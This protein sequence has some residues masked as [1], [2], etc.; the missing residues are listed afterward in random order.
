MKILGISCYYHDSAAALLEDAKII[1][2]AEEERFSRIKHDSSFPSKSVEFC[3]SKSK[4]PKV[5]DYV[6]FYEKP[7][8]KFER[9]LKQALATFPYSRPLFV[10]AMK[11]WLTEKLWIK[12]KISQELQ[13]SPSKVYFSDHHA[14]HAASAFYPSPYKSAAILTIDGVGEWSTASY[15][16]GKEN[17][18]EIIKELRFPHSLGLLYSVFTAFLGFEV[19]DGEYK[20]MG[21]APYGKPRFKSK[22]K[23]IVNILDDGSIK[24]D[25]DYF[26][27]HLSPDKAFD[28]KFIQLFGEPRDKNEL[29]FTQKTGYPKFWGPKPK[30]FDLRAKKNERYADIAASIQEITEEIILKMCQHLYKE[31]NIPN[32]CLAGGV[33]LNSVA[34]GKI[35]REGPFKNLW[36][37]PAASDAGGAL[38]SALYLYHQILNQKDRQRIYHSFWGKSYNAKEIETFLINNKIKFKKL[39]DSDLFKL[40]AKALTQ[41]KVVAWFE[42]RFEWGPRALGHRSILADPRYPDMKDIVN[43]K[44]KFREPYRPFAPAVLQER[45]ADF[46]EISDPKIETAKYMLV[47]VPVKKDKGRLIPAVNHLGTSRIQTVEN[48]KNGRFAKLI[49]EFYK[50]TG[51]PMVMNTSLNLRGEPIVNSPEDAYNTFVKSGIDILVMENFVIEK[52][53]SY[54]NKD[55]A[56]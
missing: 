10:E 3:L 38:G 45:A 35:I 12:Q 11:K 54:K 31:T 43:S 56:Q 47:V 27:F 46:F 6:V 26:T 14:S 39:A 52:R 21:M 13:I 42:G 32:L 1:A 15:G 17:K 19:N 16:I 20:V 55:L 49:N 4:T 30:N 34:N 36:V 2:M 53:D 33:A 48:N 50:I 29:F 37:Q 5:I 51:I 8:I 41:K 40:I 7:F 22:I 23:K 25:L 9:I 18:I 24:L 28:K 44:I